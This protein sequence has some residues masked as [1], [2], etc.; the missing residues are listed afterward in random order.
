MAPDA[1]RT[2]V[3]GLPALVVVLFAAAAIAA[4][5]GLARLGAVGLDVEIDPALETISADDLAARLVD[6]LRRADPPFTVA[7]SAADRIRLIV[8][9]RPVSATTLRG[10][11]LPFSGTYAVGAVELGV[12]RKVVLPGAPGASPAV[13]WQARRVVSVPLRLAGQEVARLADDMLAELLAAR[14]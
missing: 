13:V 9:V 1:R 7:E 2:A 8:A 6:G 10:F 14:R 12:V 5:A 4:E 11:W 3:G